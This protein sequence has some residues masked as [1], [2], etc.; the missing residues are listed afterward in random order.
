MTQTTHTRLDDVERISD[1]C[2]LAM[3]LT[4]C[5]CGGGVTAIRS[6]IRAAR[7]VANKL[8]KR[9]RRGAK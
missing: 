2:R 4:H 8:H 7:I 9:H 1:D 6:T 5:S 3:V